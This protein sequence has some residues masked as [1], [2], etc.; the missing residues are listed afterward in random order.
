MHNNIPH[1]VLFLKDSILKKPVSRADE[2][3]YSAIPPVYMQLR[4]IHITA[5]WS[6]LHD[7]FYSIF[8]AP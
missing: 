3:E 7:E 1:S 5:T 4:A 6:S 8:L 2:N